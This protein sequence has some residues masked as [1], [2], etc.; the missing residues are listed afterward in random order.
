MDYISEY[1]LMPLFIMNYQNDN[2]HMKKILY[3]TK[4]FITIT[5]F[6]IFTRFICY[7]NTMIISFLNLLYYFLEIYSIFGFIILLSM[8]I[9][10][11]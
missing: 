5:A 7:L 9:I 11:K 6:I 8:S 4:C 1:T 10:Y 2:I 3:I